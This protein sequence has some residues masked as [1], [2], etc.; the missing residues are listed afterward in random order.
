MHGIVRWFVR[1]PVAANLLMVAIAALGIVALPR[2]RVEVLPE[3]EPGIVLVT[4]VHP[5][6]SPS[7]VEEAIC[8]RVE[9]AVWDV[10]GVK[11]VRSTAVEGLGSVSIEVRSDADLRDVL[12]DVKVRVDAI[13]SFPVDAEE[14]I[15]REVLVRKKVIEVA[16]SGRSDEWSLRRLAEE[17]RD[18]LLAL[19]NVSQVELAS[20]RAPEIAIETDERTLRAFDLSLDELARAVAATSID[21]PAGSVDGADGE[22][23]L[24][25]SRE[26]N[27]GARFE[28]LVVRNGPDGQRLLVRDV[29]RVVDGFRE[30]DEGARFDGLPSVQVRVFR[31]GEQSA[32]DVAT[33]VREYVAR[34]QALL[35][36]GLFVSTWGDESKI[37]RDRIDTLLTNG[38]QG[39]ALVFVSLALFLRFRLAFWV[40]FGIPLSFLGTLALMPGLDV[41]VNMISLFAFILVMGIVVDDAIVVSESVHTEESAGAS[42]ALA[43]ERGVLLV[44]GPVILS[45][46]TTIAAFLPMAFMDGMLS[47]LWFMIPAV[48]VPTL[49]FSLT[50]S[51]F[52]LPAH[53]A[54]VPQ[55]LTWC[56]GVPPFVW[57]TRAQ[58]AF[59]SWTERVAARWY[60]PILRTTLRWKYATLAAACGILL[61]SIA[62]VANGMLHFTFMPD[63]EGDVVAAR[64]E[65]PQ[66][67]PI[68]RTSAVAARVEAAAEELREELRARG[69]GEIVR[70]VF[71][72]LGSQPYRSNNQANDGMGG[73]AVSGSH[74][75]EVTL[76]LAPAEERELSAGIV[77]R[78]WRE[79]CSD[80]PPDVEL[81]VSAALTGADAD[82]QVRLLAPDPAVLLA[83]A[84]RLAEELAK[85]PGVYGIR[86]SHEEGKDEI[87]LELLPRGERLGLRQADLAHQVR[88]AFH[89]AEAQRIVRGRDDVRVMV[90]LARERRAELATLENLRLATPAGDWVPLADVARIDFTRGVARVERADR[91]RSLDVFADIDPT[92]VEKEALR[93][94]LEKRVLPE[95]EAQ[96]PG[97][98]AGFTGIEKERADSLAQLGSHYVLALIAIFALMAIPFRSYL[99]PL[100]VMSAI[101]FG[102]AGAIG[103]HLLT[104]Y[105]L[106]ML[107]VLGII[108]L[109]GVAVNDSIVLVDYVNRQLRA[110]RPLREAL[111]TAGV[112][113]FR[114]IFLTSLT[115]FAGLTPLM[116][117]TSVQAQ[118]MIPMAVS[119]AFGVVFATAITLVVV[120]CLL[121]VFVRES[122]VSTSAAV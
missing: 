43:A 50:E 109:S 105:D 8:R 122:R 73:A 86:D 27:V 12:S 65:L 23:L 118:F 24:E 34:K 101:P 85:V 13:D 82:V 64:V 62:V 57:W 36:D 2:V 52:V 30:T 103:G 16:I 31:V 56:A 112:A 77:E 68:D 88:N 33:A 35:P 71:T 32:L 108:A 7:E 76:Q 99:Q 14:P 78:R 4:V 74:L 100:L 22:I 102:I 95:L 70:H 81:I 21:L 37:L 97:L 111:E 1:N 92:R 48:V 117:E 83:G 63:I 84:E 17:V 96:F 104:G 59:A 116:L 41:S 42:P 69:E 25:S 53:L 5:G 49:V 6:A 11:E 3:L 19:P 60:A 110:G 66:G 26:A 90:R 29:A 75:A 107:S 98:R 38:A 45:V 15:A 46:L 18:E 121:A 120:P 61:V 115:T 10:D 44:Y 40:A 113:R 114:A 54:H 119:L 91:Q 55:W 47:T 28:E 9:E 94:D 72:A 20:A 89:G 79:L 67:T 87:A 80:L 51:L 93:S 106:S 39:L 58:T